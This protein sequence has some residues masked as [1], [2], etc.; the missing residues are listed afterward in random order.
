MQG[1]VTRRVSRLGFTTV[2]RR[3]AVAAVVLAGSLTLATL[4]A[5]VAAADSPPTIT[6]VAFG[7]TTSPAQG[8]TTVTVTGSG[9]GT[10]SALGTPYAPPPSGA[11][12]SDFVDDNLPGDPDYARELETPGFDFEKAGKA[13]GGREVRGRAGKGR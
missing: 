4:P 2:L 9:F 5:G 3:T 7:G 12:G 10:E 1:S 8:A 13:R 6:G 11:T